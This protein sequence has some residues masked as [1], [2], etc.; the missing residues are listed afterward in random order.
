MHGGI[1]IKKVSFTY[2]GRVSVTLVIQ[3]EM[4]MSRI[5]LCLWPV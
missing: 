3:H 2:S 1:N 5:T 4:R